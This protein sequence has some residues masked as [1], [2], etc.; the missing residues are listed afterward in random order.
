M[1]RVV[2]PCRFILTSRAGGF[3]LVLQLL[4]ENVTGD[5]LTTI[6]LWC[7]CQQRGLSKILVP[8]SSALELILPF[9]L[10][11]WEVTE[12][13][14]WFSLF[15]SA[16]HLPTDKIAFNPGKVKA[17]SNYTHQLHIR[18]LRKT[19]RITLSKDRRGLLSNLAT[20]KQN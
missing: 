3:S 2:Y 19:K 15:S 14:V 7:L 6:F 13:R 4:C 5:S 20:T 8:D 16:L 11:F 12:N 18:C 10:N 17:Q 9:L 1:R